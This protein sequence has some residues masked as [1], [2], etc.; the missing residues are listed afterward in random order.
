[1]AADRGISEAAAPR[2][3]LRGGTLM[4]SRRRP[5]S[6]RHR[7]SALLH[8]YCV[9]NLMLFLNTFL[10][11]VYP[12]V[13]S[14]FA[15]SSPST[16]SSVPFKI[17]ARVRAISCSSRPASSII[18][19]SFEGGEQSLRGSGSGTTTSRSSRR[20]H[21]AFVSTMGA[22]ANIG[23]AVLFLFIARVA[24]FDSCARQ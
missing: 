15:D 2:S 9:P 12:K 14:F 11:R 19:P 21:R 18:C 10:P 8:R 22:Y 1:M 5:Q 3:Q 4:T 13:E 16:R 20:E 24:C 17:F 23:D 7:H 6:L